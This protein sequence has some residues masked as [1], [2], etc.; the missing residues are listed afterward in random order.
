MEEGELHS[1]VVP[2]N[3]GCGHDG[4]CVDFGN[5]DDYYFVL[6]LALDIEEFDDPSY[7]FEERTVIVVITGGVSSSIPLILPDNT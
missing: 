1:C 6:H 3:P 2:L 7:I 5:C 4:I